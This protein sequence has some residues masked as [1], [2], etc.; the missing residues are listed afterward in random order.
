[1]AI[2]EKIFEMMAKATP[3]LAG[4]AFIVSISL[5]IAPA[6]FASIIPVDTLRK[7]HRETIGIVL[8]ISSAFLLVEFIVYLKKK[9]I[10]WKNRRGHISFLKNLMDDEKELLSEF[11][12]KGRT[13]VAREMSG[14]LVGGLE[15]KGIIFR[16]S[17]IGVIGDVF[18]YNIQ[19]WALR[20]LKKHKSLLQR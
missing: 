7:N 18:P 17:S 2:I 4:V 13:T 16:S 10:A 14:G 3:R 5:L 11:V 15:A 1:M 19:P 8:L 12:I 6:K 9:L 20:Y